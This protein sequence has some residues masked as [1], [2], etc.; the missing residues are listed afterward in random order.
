MDPLSGPGNVTTVRLGPFALLPNDP[1]HAAPAPVSRRSRGSPP[2]QLNLC[3]SSACRRPCQD[4]YVLGLQPDLV[5]ADG[6]P[7]NLDTG[8]DAPP[9]GLDRHRAAT[10]PVCSAGSLIGTL[11]HRVFAS[12]NERTGFSAPEGFGMP[13][14]R[15]VWGGAVELMNTSTDLKLVYIQLTSRWLPML[16]AG[17]Q[18]GHVGVAGHRQLRGLGGRHA[19]RRDRRDVGMGLDRDRPDHRRRR[20][21]STTAASGSG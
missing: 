14:G 20:A 12:G 4:C 3:R 6:S 21:T 13:V 18:A 1:G 9:R 11:G 5:Y 8:P 15:G 2:A 19:C 16:D 7:A 10:D 17:H